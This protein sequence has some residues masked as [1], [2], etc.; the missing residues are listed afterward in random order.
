MIAVYING[1]L[2]NDIKLSNGCKFTQNEKHK[3]SSTATIAVPVSAD[4]VNECDYIK[5]VDT[6]SNNTVYAGTMLSLQQQNIGYSPTLTDKIYQLNIA[7]NADFIAGIYTDMVFESGS[8]VY[9]ILHGSSAILGMINAILAVF[10]KPPITVWYDASGLLSKIRAEGITIGTVDDFSDITIEN[11]ANLWGKYLTDVL[12]DLC[13][14]CGAWWEITPDKVFNM[15]YTYSRSPAPFVLNES[16]PV[17]DLNVTRDA[18]TLYSAVRVV[19]SK[20]GQGAIIE[21]TL[22]VVLASGE[23][24]AKTV[25]ISKP[26]SAVNNK[27]FYGYMQN[28]GDFS[29]YGA[30]KISMYTTEGDFLCDFSGKVGI[31]GTDD[32]NSDFQFLYS[33]NSQTIIAKDGFEFMVSDSM[34]NL[35]YTLSYYPVVPIITRIINDNLAAEIASQRGGTGIIEYTLTDD[36]IT[37][38]ND[39]ASKAS[40]F[41]D[42]CSK[43]AETVKFKTK[44]PVSVG[45]EFTDSDVPYYGISGTYKVTSATASIISAA[46]GGMMEYEIEA[47][48]VDYRDTLSIVSGQKTKSIS[49]T[50]GEIIGLPMATSASCDLEILTAIHICIINPVTWSAIETNGN[51]SN[52]ESAYSHWDNIDN[53]SGG[54]DFMG[55]YWTAEGKTNIV[56]ALA[57]TSAYDKSLCTSYKIKL[58]DVNGNLL[59][60]VYPIG[61]AM[62]IATGTDYSAVNTFFLYEGDANGYIDRIDVINQADE[63]IQSITGINYNKTSAMTLNITK[64][65]V[66]Q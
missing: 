46:D 24:S 1:T 33:Y 40:Y 21:E 61:T 29:L 55:N 30:I 39:A 8:S 6:A 10:G 56:K 51:W 38:F 57:S 34:V 26:I 60:T 53:P 62:Q 59:K 2:R 3:T 65:D 25:S 20:T 19:G 17:Y 14:K 36:T 31:S 5:I 15:R 50:N 7:S 22:N 58:Y 47:S 54:V 52:F 43:K 28:G 4:P 63:I 48:T 49:L 44:T 66:V 37:T 16:A 35:V 64:K 27:A 23:T 11:T 42:N 45:Q 41:L 9:F 32:N 18:F 13:E 12:D